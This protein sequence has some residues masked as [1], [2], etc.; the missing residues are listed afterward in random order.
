[1][2]RTCMCFLDF[3][4]NF[5]SSCACY[6]YDEPMYTGCVSFFMIHFITKEN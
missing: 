3:S 2:E 4:V 6:V 5:V 1:M